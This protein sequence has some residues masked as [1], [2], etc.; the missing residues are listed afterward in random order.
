M[1][2]SIRYY[3]PDQ[4]VHVVKIKALP[5]FNSLY[6]PLATINADIRSKYL[7]AMLG[8]LESIDFLTDVLTMT[9]AA[10]ALESYPGKGPSRYGIQ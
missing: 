10:S 6:H 5:V 3:S 1:F 8:L 4:L 2:Y 9:A 7:I